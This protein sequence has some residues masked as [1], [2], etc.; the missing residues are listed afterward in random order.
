MIHSTCKREGWKHEKTIL[1]CWEVEDFFFHLVTVIAFLVGPC[2]SEES[3]QMSTRRFAKFASVPVFWEQ[4]VSHWAHGWLRIF[5]AWKSTEMLRTCQSCDNKRWSFAWKRCFN[6]SFEVYMYTCYWSLP[7][8]S[9]PPRTWNQPMKLLVWLFDSIL[10]GTQQF[11][12]SVKKQKIRVPFLE[13][14]LFLMEMQSWNREGTSTF[15][16]RSH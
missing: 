16:F 7:F 15:G 2:L 4:F 10:H 3:L 5:S 14:V 12:G 1:F 6:M 8:F 9:I 13:F 11:S